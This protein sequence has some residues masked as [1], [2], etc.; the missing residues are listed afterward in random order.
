VRFDDDAPRVGP[1]AEA[2]GGRE[3]RRG[4][5]AKAPVTPAHEPRDAK[6]ARGD[7]FARAIGPTDPRSKVAQSIVRLI[8]LAHHQLPSPTAR[9]RRGRAAKSRTGRAPPDSK[10]AENPLLSS[11]SNSNKGAPFYLALR[12]APGLNARGP[13]RRSVFGCTAACN[14]RCARQGARTDSVAITKMFQRSLGRKPELARLERGLSAVNES[15]QSLHSNE[16]STVTIPSGKP[17]D[18]GHGAVVTPLRS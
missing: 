9:L 7:P 13:C 17:G 4:S 14:H 3:L 5:G 11:W 12:F 1:R 16:A 18:T 2:S 8:R 10:G 6:W 15:L